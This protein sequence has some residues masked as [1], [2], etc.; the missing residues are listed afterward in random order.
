MTR[1]GVRRARAADADEAATVLRASITTLCVADHGN[2]GAVLERWLSNKTPCDVRT[3]IECPGV[4]VVVAQAHQG[5][6]GVGAA[7]PTGEITLNYVAPKARFR[8]VSK[9]MLAA[10]EEHLRTRGHAR[11]TLY[12]TRT[13]LRF[14]RAMGYSDADAPRTRDGATEYRMFKDFPTRTHQR[15]APP[16]ADPVVV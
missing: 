15:A 11:I 14:Y 3:W 6:V 1:F 2:D 9:A 8:G 5:L 10:L 13:A 7:A 4:V 16:F 12:S